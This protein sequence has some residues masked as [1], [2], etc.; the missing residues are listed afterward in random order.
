VGFFFNNNTNGGF[1]LNLHNDGR[2][3]NALDPVNNQDYVTL[4]YANANYAGGSGG[5]VNHIISPDL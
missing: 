3:I 4:A 5:A 2:L 1:D